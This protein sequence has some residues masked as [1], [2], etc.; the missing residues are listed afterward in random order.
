M[1][2]ADFENDD[3]ITSDDKFWAMLAYV[4]MPPLVSI[5]ILLS[6]SKRQRPFIRA[7]N[8]QALIW[9]IIAL[10]FGSLTAGQ[11]WM[12]LWAISIYWGF[13]HAHKGELVN[14]PV[15]TEFVKTQGWG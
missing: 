2:E 15:I 4:A 14:I 1:T 3:G 7:H 13:A 9:G 12:I 6:D 5:V 8:A 11:G 10:L